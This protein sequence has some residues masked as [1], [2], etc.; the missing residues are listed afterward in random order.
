[1][2]ANVLQV[3]LLFL[4]YIYVLQLLPHGAQV[5]PAEFLCRETASCKDHKTKILVHNIFCFC[6]TR[7][8]CLFH[9]LEHFT[10]KNAF[11]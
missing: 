1:M 4:P 11:Q 6:I 9:S 2:F 8:I 5:V 3:V 7:L 10:N